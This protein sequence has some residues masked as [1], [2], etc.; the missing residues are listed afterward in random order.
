[1]KRSGY[2][3]AVAAFAAA[4]QGDVKQAA[5]YVLDFADFGHS[6]RRAAVAAGA[7]AATTAAAAWA[8]VASLAWMVVNSTERPY[9]ADISPH[10]GCPIPTIETIAPGAAFPALSL[11]DG[12]PIAVDYDVL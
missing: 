12:E 6:N 5:G 1:M 7:A 4:A 11:Q 3:A 2:L 9:Q 8:A 10:A